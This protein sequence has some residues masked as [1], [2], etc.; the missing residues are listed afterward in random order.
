M[1]AAVKKTYI[2]IFTAFSII[3][4]A[5]CLPIFS[6]SAKADEIGNDAAPAAKIV[7]HAGDKTFSYTDEKMI[8]SDFTVAEEIERR[9]INAPLKD[10]LE[11][12]DKCL[13]RGADY[14]T[15]LNVCF[16]LLVREAEKA[17]EYLSVPPADAHVEYNNGT[18]YVADEKSGRKLDENKLYAGLYYTLKYSGG[19]S[20][21]AATVPVEPTVKKSDFVGK[22]TLRSEYTTDYARSSADR[23]H[24]VTLALGKFDGLR[25]PA[26]ETLSFNA[27]VGA[28]TTENGFKTAKIIIDGKYTD[29][30]GGGVCQASTA[31]YN[32]ALTA[33]MSCV[34]NAHSICPSYCPA[35]LDAMISS[36]SDLLIT[37]TSESDVYI[38]VRASGGRATV[39]MYGETQTEHI[40]AESVVTSTVKCNTEEFTDAE[41]KY[42]DASA[43]T[44]DRLLVSPG[45]DGVSSATYLTYYVDGKP[46]KRVKIRENEYR[47]VPNVIA[48]AP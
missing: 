17:G 7:I 28:R 41:H 21:D 10:K 12:V 36:V 46:I 6:R 26:G 5:L 18:F 22:L 1:K 11:L 27:T 29:G 8:P 2:S 37:N 16:P 35:G 47:C 44:G 19:G 3:S 32:A 40:V 14:K 25:L 15:A 31:V 42:F 34:A 23:R 4:A 43:P 13:S 48:V 9:K 45:K 38:S 24:N 33:G 20:V 39:R 30:V